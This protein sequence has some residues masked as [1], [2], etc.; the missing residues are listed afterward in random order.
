MNVTQHI[1]TPNYFGQVRYC[2][3]KKNKDERYKDGRMQTIVG[4]H[5]I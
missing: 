1:L 2:R 5:G 4:E 3:C